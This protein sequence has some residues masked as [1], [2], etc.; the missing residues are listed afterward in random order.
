M[1]EAV[2]A[3]LEYIMGAA[4]TPAPQ[5]TEAPQAETPAAPLSAG[6]DDNPPADTAAEPHEGQQE[7][8]QSPPKPKGG[9]QRRIDELTKR[10]STAERRL[11]QALAMLQR[12]VGGQ[13]QQ[14]Q[15]PAQPQGPKPPSPDDFKTYDDYIDARA[16]FM[17]EQA[18]VKAANSALEQRLR[19][20]Q[21]QTARERLQ[22]A[23]EAVKQAFTERRAEYVKSVPDFDSVVESADFEVSAALGNALMTN[24][25][26]PALMYH[27]AK[28]P[29]L[30]SRLSR[31]PTSEMNFELGR[32]AAAIASASPTVS[33]APPPGRPVGGGAE[34]P[35]PLNTKQPIE[36]WAAEFN[37]RY[38]GKRR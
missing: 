12:T 38:F 29:D 7:G 24:P 26:G 4:P 22:Q 36:K 34:P 25:M 16:A 14:G 11:E 32:I 6:S 18:A 21:E 13:Q 5:E 28:Q 31:M 17:A 10:A 27:L 23:T 8:E 2:S 37:R 19:A 33:K 30:G 1:S 20:A 35:D 9:F 3:N 15:Q